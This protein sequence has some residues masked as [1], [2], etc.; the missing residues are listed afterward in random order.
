MAHSIEKSTMQFLKDIDKNN[1]RDWFQENKPYYLEAQGNVIDFVESVLQNMA[2]YDEE[3]VKTDV[4]KALFRIYRDTR[5]SKDK[6]PYKTNFGISLGIG[7]GSQNAG[8]YIHIEP[9][10]SF[11]GAGLYQPDSSNLKKIR[12]EISTY[13]KEF[14]DIIH[15]KNFQ[16]FYP[17]LHQED[18]LKNPPQGF[19]KENPM[20]EYLKLKNVLV[21]HKLSDAQVF[22][23]DS[24]TFVSELFEVAQPFNQFINN[25]IN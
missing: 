5:F 11:V 14:L 2:T 22:S 24:A 13:R 1:N 12:S 4:K 25:A 10:K 21:L 19:D 8:Y 7:K 18:K 16:K 23:K 20:I 6:T 17:E 3:I 9:G 15:S